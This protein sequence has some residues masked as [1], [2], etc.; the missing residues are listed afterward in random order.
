MASA[1]D[2]AHIV[3]LTWI[4]ARTLDITIDSPA[5]GGNEPVRLLLPPDW[6]ARPHQQW[7][8]LY[9]LN[10]CCNTVS[11]TQW[12]TGSDVEQFTAGTDVLV[13]MPDGG[14]DGFFSNW[15]N[16]GAGGPPAWET[17]HL[18]ELRQILQRD[19]RASARMAVAG[20]SMGG[21]GAM[22]YAETGL[23][24][25]AASYS[26][27]LDPLS[28][29]DGV[30]EGLYPDALWG[31]PVAQRDIWI[32]ND[33]TDNVTRLRGVK[34][35]VASGNGT[36]DPAIT[37]STV[38][39]QNELEV[40]HESLNFVAALKKAHVPVTA[41]F[42]GDGTHSWYY[43]ERDFHQSYPML[44]KAIGARQASTTTTN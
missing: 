35:F 15:W 9:L 25:A 1:N 21:Y 23:F 44:M 33:P 7:P 41:D 37:T 19:F 36:P 38:I 3:S 34:L 8:V 11:Y 12:Y 39:D 30:F 31:D 6:S 32:A 28:N 16:E 14:A 43:W 24:K 20:L 18:T 17:F 42:Y 22:K 10:G 27:V 40:Y 4:D 5:M 13:V 26:G 2:G 29:P